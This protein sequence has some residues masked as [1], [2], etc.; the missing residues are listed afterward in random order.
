MSAI[1]FGKLNLGS[2]DLQNA[3]NAEVLTFTEKTEWAKKI[4]GM[5]EDSGVKTMENIVFRSKGKTGFF[6]CPRCGL[7]KPKDEIVEY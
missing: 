6:Y 2:R 1:I 7:R 4:I 5:E 3:Q